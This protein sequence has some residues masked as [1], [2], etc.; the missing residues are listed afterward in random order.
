M[1]SAWHGVELRHLAALDAVGAER[2]FRGAAD[3]LGYVQSA[4]SQQISQFESLVGA[5]LIERERGHAAVGLTDAGEVLRAHAERVLSQ[6]SAA[7]ADLASLSDG[8]QATVRVGATQSVAARVLP[9]ALA[10]LY[11]RR[12][13]LRVEVVERRSDGEFFSALAEGELDLAFTEV[14]I[15]AGPFSSCKLFE[16]P[17]VLVVTAGRNH[18]APT[19]PVTLAEVAQ[20]PLVGHRGWR[21]GELVEA[22][23]RARGLELRYVAHA[24]SDA[25]AQALVAS[26]R[27]SAIMPCL[28]VAADD[29]RTE[30]LALDPAL[31]ARTLALCW[32]RERRNPDALEAFCDAALDACGERFA[33]RMASA[34][35]RRHAEARARLARSI[36]DADAQPPAAAGAPA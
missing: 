4:V 21:F 9:G 11:E 10:L 14:P 6:L 7:R 13:E 19:E 15:A 24:D 18:A 2:S 35:G 34:R 20:R 22:Q 25:T 33:G 16:D 3:R 27:A 5:R 28:A 8:E 30:A 23:F 31:P 1:T 36:A 12:P 32:H 29:P 26:G 17:C